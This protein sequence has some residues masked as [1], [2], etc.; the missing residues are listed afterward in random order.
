MD[1]SQDFATPIPST[2]SQGS[3][4]DHAP[5]VAPPTAPTVDS[6][7]LPP[8]DVAAIDELGRAY[9]AFRNELGKTIIGQRGRGGDWPGSS[10]RACC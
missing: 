7:G 2:D 8:D 3:F 9:E 4:T 10:A 5:V 6:N 1:S